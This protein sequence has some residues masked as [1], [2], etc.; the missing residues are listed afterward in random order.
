MP[1]LPVQRYFKKPE[2][3]AVPPDRNEDFS[4]LFNQ[5]NE[6]SSPGYRDTRQRVLEMP[7]Y[8][9][10]EPRIYSKTSGDEESLV[11][12]FTAAP[13]YRSRPT[14]ELAL[15]PVGRLAEEVSQIQLNPAEEAL[16]M[17]EEEEPLDIDALVHD[18]Y[19][20]LR[21]RLKTDRERERGLS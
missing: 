15:A 12:A 19:S 3:D 11:T 18:V 5:E 17:E 2:A 7:P 9:I 8:F 4:F 21:W 1:V 20:K 16:E 6:P 10:A 13:Y 14:P